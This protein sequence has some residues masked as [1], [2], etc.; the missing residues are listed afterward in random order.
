[1]FWKTAFP[2]IGRLLETFDQFFK[3][4]SFFAFFLDKTTIFI[5]QFYGKIATVNG[6]S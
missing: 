5:S 3:V 1:M 2:K 4:F 6:T